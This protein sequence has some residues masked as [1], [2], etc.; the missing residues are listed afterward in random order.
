MGGNAEP[1][2]AKVH[3]MGIRHMK[4]EYQQ[5]HRSGRPRPSSPRGSAKGGSPSSSP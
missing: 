4:D 2:V 1:P 5:L 3:P